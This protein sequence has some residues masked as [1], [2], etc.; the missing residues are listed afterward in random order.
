APTIDAL[1]PDIYFPNF[2]EWARAYDIPSN[3]YFVPETGRQPEATPANAFYAFAAH[4]SMG[5]SPFA[6]EDFAADDD[7]G[8][9]YG[10]LQGLT[11]IILAHQGDGS[12][13]GVRPIVAFDGSVD[14]A[15]QDVTLGGYRLH[16]TFGNPFAAPVAQNQA[17][18]GAQGQAYPPGLNPAA[19]G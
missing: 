13:V 8:K 7:L 3:P 16:V 5:F 15:P 11:P 14:A 9:A 18:P 6:I 19:Y 10:V 17:A 1:S 2:V 12:M 4:D